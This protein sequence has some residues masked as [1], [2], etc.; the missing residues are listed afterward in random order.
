[1]ALYLRVSTG[2]Q[3]T[4]NQRRELEAAAERHGWRIAAVFEDAG[5]SGAKGRKD[6]PGLDAMLKAVARREVDLVMAWSV[7]RLGRSLVDLLTTL[8][9]LHAKEVDLYLHQQGLDTS[10]PSGRAMFGMMGVFSEFERSMIQERVRAGLARARDEG[11]TLGRPTLEKMIRR[12]LQG[13]GD[14]CSRRRRT[15]DRQRA[16]RRRRHGVAA[17][18]AGRCRGSLRSRRGAEKPNWPAHGRPGAFSAWHVA[19]DGERVSVSC[20]YLFCLQLSLV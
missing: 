9:E 17:D 13:A 8:Q 7:D 10:T 18:I 5:I 19:Q 14:A 15:Q 3:T 12:E 4:K 6:R 2:E 20:I 11:I 1:M 16:G